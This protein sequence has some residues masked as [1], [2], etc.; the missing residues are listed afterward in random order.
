MAAVKND[1]E[2]AQARK[3]LSTAVKGLVG[4]RLMPSLRIS[5]TIAEHNQPVR[6]I[7]S[8]K[9]DPSFNF[10]VDGT[11]RFAGLRVSLRG[12]FKKS[13][14]KQKNAIRAARAILAKNTK[15][16]SMLQRT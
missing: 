10:T 2:V 8:L 15:A 7:I 6:H 16:L 3:A 4:A 14:R 11:K 1:R 12:L 13:A 9:H 5:Q